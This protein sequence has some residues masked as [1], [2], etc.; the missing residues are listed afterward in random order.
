M[1]GIEAEDNKK[2]HQLEK[3]VTHCDPVQ[4]IK[5]APYRFGVRFGKQ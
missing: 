2:L 5:N 3:I 4:R 1:E